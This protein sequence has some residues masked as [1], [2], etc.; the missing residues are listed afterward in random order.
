MIKGL[1]S[2]KQKESIGVIRDS[3]INGLSIEQINNYIDNNVV[4]LPSAK[5]YLKKISKVMLYIL[6]HSNLQ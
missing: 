5:A 3:F 6:R 2:E 4:D 1:R